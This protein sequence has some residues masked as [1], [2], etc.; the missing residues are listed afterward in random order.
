MP[1]IFSFMEIGESLNSRLHLNWTL[2]QFSEERL[3]HTRTNRLLLITYELDIL[4][5]MTTTVMLIKYY[6]LKLIEVE[7]NLTLFFQ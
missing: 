1:V 2:L 7:L 5:Y 6:I 3:Y 4:P